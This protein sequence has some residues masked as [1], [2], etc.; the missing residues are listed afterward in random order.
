MMFRDFRHSW[1]LRCLHPSSK[2]KGPTDQDTLH[3]H[4]S[5]PKPWGTV[6]QCPG[7]HPLFP[8]KLSVVPGGGD[9]WFDIIG[10]A[11]NP[12]NPGFKHPLHAAMGTQN[13][14]FW[15]L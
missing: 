13:L 4:K 10:G 2:K 3:K 12:Q 8:P 15:G 5:F 7:G 14:H 11:A 6:V 9:P 1:C